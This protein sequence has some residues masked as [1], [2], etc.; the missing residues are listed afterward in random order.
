MSII[1][2]SI[3]SCDNDN[4]DITQSKDIISIKSFSA[5]ISSSNALRA[6]VQISFTGTTNYKIEYWETKDEATKRT[7]KSHEGI[8]NSSATIIILKPE[9]EYSYCIIYDGNK[10]SEVKTFTTLAAPVAIPKH[11]L[12]IDEINEDFP[13]YILSYNRNMPGSVYLMDTKGNLVWYELIREGV[14]VAN[15]DTKTNRIYMLTG[16]TSQTY[17]YNGQYV[18]VIDLFGNTILSK[19]LTTIPELADRQIHHECRPLPDRNIIMVSYVDRK[20]DL[21]TQGGSEHE[22]VKGDGFVIM[23]IE[24]NVTKLWDCFDKLNPAD[25]P[26]IMSNRT[27]WLH[28]NSI[29]YDSEGNYY[30]TFNTISQLWKIDAKTGEVKYRVGRDGTINIP[31]EGKAN[32]MHCANPQ[33]PDEVL[34][35]DNARSENEGSRAIMYKV[36][37]G[38]KSAEITINSEL[39]LEYSSPNRSNVQ[40][41]ADNM[42]LFG[43][44]T[45]R[46]ILF[47]DCQ[48]KAKVLRAISTP[49]IFYRVEYIPTIEY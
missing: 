45:A 21:R 30:M 6:E 43:S 34:I 11:D 16:P 37:E 10:K 42:L 46:L 31:E 2:F 7:T 44:G 5:S 49:Q 1:I 25:D 3:L 19:D 20:F 12:Y 36:N 23:N 24:G 29:N 22:M 35:I 47:T 32:G 28:A 14:L 8:T 48:P 18:K 26:K 38:Q 13:G 41:I 17:A 27:D 9:T 40:K 4:D 15:L 33:S 39:P